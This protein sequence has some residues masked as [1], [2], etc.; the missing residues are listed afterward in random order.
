MRF[1]YSIIYVASVPET[2]AFYE[3]AFGL[4]TGFLHES[5]LYGELKTGATTLA[6]AADE[7]AQRNGLSVRPNRADERPA[8]YEIALVTDDPQRAFERAVSAG[9]VAVSAPQTKP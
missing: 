9:A 2:L 6:F 7:M 3:K 4:Q 1:G 8:G 5:E